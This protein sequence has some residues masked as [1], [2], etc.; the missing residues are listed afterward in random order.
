MLNEFR[1]CPESFRSRHG[2]GLVRDSE[3]DALRAGR[4]WHEAMRVWFADGGLDASLLA[5]QTAWG[6]EP[7]FPGPQKRPLGLF[8]NLLR[9]YSER[10][11]R[12]RDSF[13]VVRNEEWID[14]PLADILI[15]G[16]VGWLAQSA[17]P[18]GGYNIDD[19]RYGGRLDRVIELDG[20]RYVMDTKTTS[21]NLTEAYFAQYLLSSQLRGYVALELVH[22]R[23]CEGIYVDAVHVDT[24]YQKAKP[25]HCQRWG[26]HRY[27]QE[28]LSEWARDAERTIGEI[29]RYRSEVGLGERWEQRDGNCFKYNKPCPYHERCQLVQALGEALPGYRRE[30]WEPWAK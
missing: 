26:P 6:V 24:R 13:T 11:P 27:A 8:E 15:G 28:Q 19:V 10:W 21:G 18:R 12:E 23:A 9:V 16:G 30:V 25:E 17:L 14:A 3:D 20:A 7:L 5:L 4:A 29:E 2:L 22:G 1:E